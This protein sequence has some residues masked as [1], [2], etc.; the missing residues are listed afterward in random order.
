MDSLLLCAFIVVT[1]SLKILKMFVRKTTQIA[2]IHIKKYLSKG[3]KCQ[4]T[5]Q[6]VFV[7]KSNFCLVSLSTLCLGFSC[8]LFMYLI[9]FIKKAVDIYMP[10]LFF[11]WHASSIF[12]ILMVAKQFLNFQFNP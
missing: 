2:L 12:K 1:H 6:I 5:I 9:Y 7:S 4:K 11:K 10:V 3:K 8:I